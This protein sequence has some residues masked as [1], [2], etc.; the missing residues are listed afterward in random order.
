MEGL[1]L[2]QFLYILE[3]AFD[4]V[5]NHQ[6]RTFGLVSRLLLLP[7]VS[8]CRSFLKI[9]VL[10]LCRSFL[11]TPVFSL[12]RS[13]LNILVLGPGRAILRLPVR[14]PGYPVD[15]VSPA[16]QNQQII[17]LLPLHFQANLTAVGRLLGSLDLPVKLSAQDHGLRICPDPASLFN[18]S[19]PEEKFHQSAD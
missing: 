17:L 10:S 11:K 1:D 16:L 19:G 6:V 2:V 5:N 12:C 3:K 4:F 18:I 9:P 15:A 14:L 8:L 7:A 13:F